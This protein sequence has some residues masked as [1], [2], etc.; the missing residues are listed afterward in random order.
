M[1][2]VLSERQRAF[3]EANH[4]A[5]M[6]TVDARGRPHAVPVLCGLVDGELWVSGTESRVRTRHLDERGYASLT[7]LTRGFWGEW[8]TV[9]GPV[10]VRRDDAIAD[11]LRLYRVAVGRDPD[12][13]EEY[14]AAMVAEGR[15]VYALTPRARLPVRTLSPPPGSRV[16]PVP[17]HG[18]T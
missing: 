2:D 3:L 10:Q 17:R 12:D 5:V 1:P 14:R 6:A 15:L 13:L 8:L 16:G 9:A 11:N 18:L 7:V 4:T